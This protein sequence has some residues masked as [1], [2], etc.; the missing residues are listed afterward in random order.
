MPSLFILEACFTHCRQLD[1]VLPVLFVVC[2]SSRLADSLPLCFPS[3]FL[4]TDFGLVTTDSV[5]P[6]SALV[7]RNTMPLTLH[8]FFFSLYP[9]VLVTALLRIAGRPWHATPSPLPCRW[10]SERSNM[11]REG[12]GRGGQP[13]HSNKRWQNHI[14]TTS[15]HI[16]ENLSCWRSAARL[17]EG[18]PC[19]SSQHNPRVQWHAA[20]EGDVKHLSQG[21]TT[22]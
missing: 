17:Q 18:V 16:L 12:E 4:C 19:L 7:L 13:A 21:T 20:Q 11:V 10:L 14:P 2:C 6:F 1:C 8:M 9:S 22:S 15:Y 3:C 5:Q